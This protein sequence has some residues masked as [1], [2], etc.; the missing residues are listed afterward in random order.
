MPIAPNPAPSGTSQGARGVL[1]WMVRA[2]VTEV[3]LLRLP[4]VDKRTPGAPH[5]AIAAPHH[6]SVI[7]L[8]NA[9]RTAA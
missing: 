5:V 1:G 4:D 2:A 6:K 7:L 9:V 3:Y 8:R